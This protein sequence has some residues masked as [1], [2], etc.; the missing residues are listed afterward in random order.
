MAWHRRRHWSSDWAIALYFR[1]REQGGGSAA[2]P[3]STLKAP[4]AAMTLL[5]RV[6]M[7]LHSRP[8]EQRSAQE[9]AH[10]TPNAG[11][12]RGPPLPGHTPLPPPSPRPLAD[13]LQGHEIRVAVQFAGNVCKNAGRDVLQARRG[14]GWCCPRGQS[15][16]PRW[17]D[18]DS[19]APRRRH[20]ERST[21]PCVVKSPALALQC[22][23]QST[24]CV[25]RLRV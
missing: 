18:N 16:P 19:R 14:R 12:V 17:V 22:P 4:C 2:V 15:V 20:G 1:R 3:H 5:T 9:P 10:Q 8:R 25:A 23:K 6:P 11:H 13:Q 7:T 21:L 24:G